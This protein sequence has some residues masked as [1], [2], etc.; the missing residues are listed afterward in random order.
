[1]SNPANLSPE[2][3]FQQRAATFHNSMLALG[4]QHTKE[5]E[6]LFYNTIPNIQNQ[7]TEPPS[8]APARIRRTAAM[9]PYTSYINWKNHSYK[10]EQLLPTTTTPDEW[11]QL[12][13]AYEQILNADTT[14]VDPEKTPEI[15]MTFGKDASNADEV[16]IKYFEPQQDT[17]GAAISPKITEASIKAATVPVMT[18]LREYATK[19]KTELLEVSAIRTEARTKVS[20]LSE[21]VDPT[22]TSSPTS[23]VVKAEAGGPISKNPVLGLKN[24]EEAKV[25]CAVNSTLQMIFHSPGLYAQLA[26]NRH[27]AAFFTIYKEPVTSKPGTSSLNTLRVHRDLFE[28]TESAAGVLC[29]SQQDI[30]ETLDKLLEKYEASESLKVP[31]QKNHYEMTA[32]EDDREVPILSD[33]AMPVLTKTKGYTL[34]NIHLEPDRDQEDLFSILKK[35]YLSLVTITKNGQTKVRG[36]TSFA[37]PPQTLILRASRAKNENGN[38]VINKNKVNMPLTAAFPRQ[39]VG[40]ST[41]GVNPNYRLSGFAVHTKNEGASQSANEGHYISYITVIEEGQLC[42]YQMDDDKKTIV[43]E[44]EFLAAAQNFSLAFYERIDEQEPES[45]SAP[46]PVAAVSTPAMRIPQAAPPKK[47]THEEVM[48]AIKTATLE[49]TRITDNATWR[50]YK[51]KDGITIWHQ[52]KQLK[53]NQ[54]E[55]LYFYNASSEEFQRIGPVI[56]TRTQTGSTVVEINEDEDAK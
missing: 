51:T 30:L 4:I 7:S 45:T 2:Q 8:L 55:S 26:S 24:N 18:K 38:I 42:Y 31:Y 11:K 43:T 17:A 44:E 56:E 33:Q 37:K 3:S 5:V 12:V 52:E 46:T 25:S 35:Q 32:F 39:L 40:A 41:A 1:M 16:K 49:E 23:P 48:D 29:D 28:Q 34:P 13:D 21:H 9:Q 54:Y 22:P 10:V 53:E 6:K 19:H 15:E 20:K 47:V 14:H 36:I 50:I 27:I